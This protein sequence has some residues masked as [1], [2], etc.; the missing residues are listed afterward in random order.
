M[1]FLIILSILVDQLPDGTQAHGPPLGHRHRSSIAGN[2]SSVG[3]EGLLRSRRSFTVSVMDPKR[4]SSDGGGNRGKKLKRREVLEKKKAVD[5][6]IGAAYSDGDPLA[7]FPDFRRY[8]KDGLS[9]CL[10]SGHGSHLSSSVKQYIQN[11]LKMNM[12]GPYGPEWPEEE[13]VKRRE[14]VAPEALYLF[15]HETT[16]EGVNVVPLASDDKAVTKKTAGQMGSLIGFV[17]YRFIVEEELPVLYVYE[18][19]LEPRAQGKGLGKFL[20][21]LVEL[22]ARKNR[23]GAVMLTVQKANVPALNFYTNRLRY[24]VSAISPSRVDLVLLAEKSYEILCKAFDP[25][26]KVILEDG[27]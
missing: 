5:E 26:A 21:Q 19:Q 25:E 23:M 27:C 6:L 16:N 20:M 2:G 8:S 12:E 13:K 15:V 10:E 17:H 14:T 1:P 22:I 11:I 24:V 4:P 3:E 18:L 7:S 9:V